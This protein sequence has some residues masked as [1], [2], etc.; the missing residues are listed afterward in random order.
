M[1]DIAKA[2]D[3]YYW[4]LLLEKIMDLNLQFGKMIDDLN[5]LLQTPISQSE[6]LSFLPSTIGSYVI[7]FLVVFTVSIMWSLIFPSITN[8][9]KKKSSKSV[10]G[11]R[12]R[13]KSKVK[14]ISSKKP[15]VLKSES[16]ITPI[17][18]PIIKEELPPFPTSALA[19]PFPVNEELTE[20]ETETETDF[21]SYDE[22]SDEDE[23][24][25]FENEETSLDKPT[26]QLV[27]EECNDKQSS[28][29][30]S[31]WNYEQ[32]PLFKVALFDSSNQQINP[33]MYTKNNMNNGILNE[34]NKNNS[35][36]KLSNTFKKRGKK[37]AVPSSPKPLLPTILND[38]KENVQKVEI[39]SN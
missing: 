30:S 12:I 39:L 23:F 22:M 17:P 5:F 33:S 27:V 26:N 34:Q 29:S 2:V 25:P 36:I 16:P 10:V 9:E 15:S 18:Q 28:L 35:S 38:D 11:K 20:T 14:K 19:S 3:N 37:M 6:T 24:I 1:S 8:N 7:L 32:K 4:D 31:S 13:S 21:D